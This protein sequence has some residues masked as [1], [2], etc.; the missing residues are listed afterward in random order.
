MKKSLFI[1]MLMCLYLNT[2]M[3]QNLVSGTVIDINQNPLPGVT[4]VCKETSQGTIT[5]VDGKYT[6][7]IGENHTLVFSLVG[8]KTENVPVGGKS[9]VNVTM[10]ESAIELDEVVAIGYGTAKKSDLTSSIVSIKPD[11]LSNVKVGS[12]ADALQGLAT[13]VLISKG[14]FKPGGSSNIIIRGNGSFGNGG[15]S[16]TPL[17]IIDGVMSNAGLDVIAPSDIESIEVLKDAAST[18]IYGSRASNGIILVT[19]KKGKSG[20]A[21]IT[22]NTNWG[23]QQFINKQDVLNAAQFK[24]VLDKAT[25]N[26]YL[27]DKEE[28]RMFETGGSTDWQDLITQSGFYQNYNLGISGGTDKNTYYLGLDWVDQE[29]II[30]NTGY[31]KG[32]LRF[33]LDSK[34][35]KWLTM[36]V[37]FNVI[38]SSTNSSN[39]DGVAGMNSL[40]QGTVGSAVASKP[41]APVFNEDGTYYDNLLLRPNPL[42]AVTYFKNNLY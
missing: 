24:E 36:G 16:N 30:K 12:A 23:V 21:K 28:L 22:F 4:V 32:S 42:A 29:G 39:T 10:Y 18:A 1:L 15:A 2:S 5:D 33:N 14:S 37:K 8:M 26:T 25:D 17:Y 20:K 19:T 11:E 13:G 34:L 9:T 7:R 38:R 27:W 41:T 40:D 31:Q 3:A 6:I 35:N